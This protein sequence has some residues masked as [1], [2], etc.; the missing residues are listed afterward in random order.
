MINTPTGMIKIK[1][2]RSV[3]YAGDVTLKSKEF[4]LLIPL[5]KNGHLN[6]LKATASAATSYVPSCISNVR[7][8]TGLCGKRISENVTNFFLFFLTEYGRRNLKIGE[9]KDV[10]I[11]VD[12]M[13]KWSKQKKIFAN[14]LRL[15]ANLRLWLG[16]PL[17]SPVKRSIFFRSQLQDGFIYNL[18]RPWRAWRGGTRR[19]L[20]NASW[21]Q[22]SGMPSKA[23]QEV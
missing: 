10:C 1:I 21:Y 11:N 13:G 14:C 16:S 4:T 20:P 8:K 17:M 9:N 22:P 3:P 5:D 15:L 12:I 18:Q 6:S 23:G 19:L 2:N 7:N